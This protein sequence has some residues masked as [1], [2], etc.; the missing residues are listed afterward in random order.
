M[1]SDELFYN[2]K[3]IHISNKI[4]HIKTLFCRI[5][6]KKLPNGVIWNKFFTYDLIKNINICRDGISIFQTNGLFIKSKIDIFQNNYK[7][8]KNGYIFKK[9]DL[10]FLSGKDFIFEIPLFNSIIPL[11]YFSSVTIDM[12]LNKEITNPTILN[13]DI[14]I[15]FKPIYIDL[16]EKYSFGMTMNHLEKIIIQ[17]DIN[18]IS[19]KVKTGG[20]I[21]YLLFVVDDNIKIESIEFCYFNMVEKYSYSDLNIILPY[22]YLKHKIPGEYL[23]NSFIK[24]NQ[25]G[26]NFNNI[27]DFII[28]FNFKKNNG[29]SIYL[30]SESKNIGIISN[31]F[32][33]SSFL[34]YSYDDVFEKNISIIKRTNK[35]I[36]FKYN[37]KNEKINLNYNMPK[38]CNCIIC[39]KKFMH[40]EI[41]VICNRCKNEFHLNCLDNNNNNI[42]K[43]CNCDH[44]KQ[45]KV[46]N[47]NLS[48]TI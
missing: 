42:C 23:F 45:Y 2:N 21:E 31:D 19:Y 5:Y 28:N 18:K 43:N 35:K 3:P 37:D 39:F 30:V 44:L 15:S 12:E 6:I 22:Y 47:L 46:E 32:F 1:E 24:N 40:D 26:F 25:G 41:Y 34:Q 11:T 20:L 9:K 48:V 36:K 4:F 8:I 17:K 10:V 29:G 7:T 13:N 33:N 27:D 16:P 38:M 14:K